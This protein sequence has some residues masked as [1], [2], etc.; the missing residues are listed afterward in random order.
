VKPKI[1]FLLQIILSSPR[2]HSCHRTAKIFRKLSAEPRLHEI[3]TLQACER[4]ET[5]SK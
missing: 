1:L 2:H 4:Y 3:H 5:S